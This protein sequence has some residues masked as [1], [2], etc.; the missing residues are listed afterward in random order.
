[1]MVENSEPLEKTPVGGEIIRLRNVG[2]EWEGRTTLH[3]VNMSVHAGDFIAVTGP[4]GGGKTTLMRI[5]LHL[6]KPTCGSVEYL[7]DGTPVSRLAIGYLPQKNHIDSRFPITTSEVILSGLSAMPFTKK[8][9]QHMLGRILETIDLA[10]HASKPIG[11]LSGGQ[12][13]RALLG[14]ALISSPSTLVL[15][16]PL[17]Y[18]DKH[19]E[20]RVYQILSAQAAS[21]TTIIIV[22][23][24]MSA[25]SGMANRH[26]IVDRTLHECTSHHHQVHFDCYPQ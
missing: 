16:E 11:T 20:Q 14:R 21:G 19:F 2:M 10:D 25:I 6:L 5:L 23:H 7:R 9:R 24:E 1:M 17:S 4:N 12:L 26:F 18:L 8:E 22:S 15:D 3:D 13:Q